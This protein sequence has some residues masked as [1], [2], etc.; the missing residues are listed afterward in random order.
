[1][2]IGLIKRG[3]SNR[4]VAVRNG[5]YTSVPISTISTG[6]RRV[7]V[8]ALYDVNSYRPKVKNIEGKPMFLY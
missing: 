5:A 8:D 2:A 7:D 1:M 4:L 3:E 6:E